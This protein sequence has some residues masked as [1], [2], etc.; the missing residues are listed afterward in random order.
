MNAT[1][2]AWFGLSILCDV[3]GQLCLK[4]GADRIDDSNGARSFILSL[5]REP[6]LL[7]GIAI[8]TLEIFVWL[9]ILAEAPLSIAFP[10]ASLNFIGVTLASAVFL[11]E[12]VRARQWLGAALITCGVALVARSA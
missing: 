10:V 7:G 5:Y 4:L 8:Y 6:W 9:R 11:K 2:I 3:A 12:P 1:L